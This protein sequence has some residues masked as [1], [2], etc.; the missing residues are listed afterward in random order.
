MPLFCK[1]EFKGLTKEDIFNYPSDFKFIITCNSEFIVKAQ[2]DARFRSII[3]DNI[4]TLDGQIPYWLF[5]LKYKNIKVEKISG[6]D[7]IYTLCEYAKI[8]NKKVFLLGGYPDS[9]ALSVQ[10]IREKYNIEVEGYSPP[11]EPYPFRSE[12]NAIILE[13]ISNFKPNI[14]MVGFGAKK[15]EFWIDD[16][17]E[18]LKR[19]GIEIAIGVGGSFDFVSGK[20]KRAPKFIQNIGLEGVWRLIMEP[21][22]FRVKRL[23]ISSMIFYYF[24]KEEV[25]KC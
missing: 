16:N 25:L 10:K 4:A 9:N 22:L 11:Y 5:K 20:I 2:K 8:Y 17:K 18:I 21:R 13:K 23:F 14:L 24:L 15:Q 1:L 7:F 3:N 6:S 12:T 19:I